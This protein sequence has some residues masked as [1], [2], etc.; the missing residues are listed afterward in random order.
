MSQK[1]MFAQ[2]RAVFLLAGGPG[3]DAALSAELL[4][5]AAPCCADLI[6]LAFP[7]HS[8]ASHVVNVPTPPDGRLPKAEALS[9][10]ASN[11]CSN[12]I[13]ACPVAERFLPFD[14][15]EI[16]LQKPPISS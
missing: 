8:A 7:L 5:E 12:C 3:G 10:A 9:S 13:W 14:C 11:C 2:R 4:N 16:S 1:G 15:L 6:W